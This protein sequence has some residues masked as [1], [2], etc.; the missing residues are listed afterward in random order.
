MA[1][2]PTHYVSVGIVRDGTHVGLA[3]VG[4]NVNPE[5]ASMDDVRTLGERITAVAREAGDLGPDMDYVVLS[6]QR[7]RG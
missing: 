5:P 6:W 2:E 3:S 7:F 1:T 4:I